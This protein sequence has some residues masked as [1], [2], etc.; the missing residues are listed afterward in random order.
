MTAHRRTRGIALNWKLHGRGGG[1]WSA[2]RP[3]R[4]IAERELRNPLNEGL[5][6]P[7]NWYGRFGEDKNLFS[8]TGF[9]RQIVYPVAYASR[10]STVRDELCPLFSQA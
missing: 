3:G 2:L 10:L 7:Q 4:F 1:E 8:L 5:G 9:E 6:E